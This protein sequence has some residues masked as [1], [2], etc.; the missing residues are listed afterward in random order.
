[1]TYNAL[2]KGRHSQ[3]GQIYFI[4]SV[5]RQRQPAFA[6]F[7]T[8]RM[9][10]RHMR[11]LERSGSLTSLAWVVMPDHLHWLFELGTKQSL[12]KVMQT[13]KGRSSTDYRHLHR[14]SAGLWQANYHDHALRAEEDL[15]AF[16]RYLVANPLRGGLVSTLGDYPHWDA[17]WL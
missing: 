17:I 4:T 12:A 13:L 6:D 2:R 8:A 14:S 9:L 15:P 7:A 11:T 3:A 5:C 10:I 16:A 1:M